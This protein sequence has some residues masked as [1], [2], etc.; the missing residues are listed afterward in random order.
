ML[1]KL[2][3]L[4]TILLSTSV[5][6]APLP[7]S[8]QLDVKFQLPK[9]DAPMYAR[10]YVAVWIENDQRQVV[11]TIQ[12]W[13]GQDEWLKDLRSWWRKSGR[14]NQSIDGLSSA[15][16]P[17]GQYRFSWDGKDDSG[18]FVEQGN[19][20]FFAEV[21]REHGGRSLLRQKIALGSKATQYTLKPTAETG[22]VSLNYQIK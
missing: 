19:Y 8:A 9:I 3:A 21:V 15:T 5:F 20:T 6:A 10:P 22:S 16:K 1:R 7:S 13:V 2:S 14:Y 18:Q 11:K 17:A 12:L 4:S